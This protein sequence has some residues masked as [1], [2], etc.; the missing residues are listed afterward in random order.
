MRLWVFDTIILNL[1]SECYAEN[2]YHIFNGSKLSESIC[3]FRKFFFLNDVD[4]CVESF[5]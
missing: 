5:P 4:V 2:F 3:N 1:E